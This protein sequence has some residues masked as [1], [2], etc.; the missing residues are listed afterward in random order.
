MNLITSDTITSRDLP[1]LKEAM[2]GYAGD[3]TFGDEFRA[4]CRNVVAAIDQARDEDEA[5][6]APLEASLSAWVVAG[7]AELQRCSRIRDLFDMIGD[8]VDAG[9]VRTVLLDLLPLLPERHVMAMFEAAASGL[10]D[11]AE[12]VIDFGLA[13]LPAASDQLH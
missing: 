11:D 1:A 9:T 10:L 4:V 8:A 6:H 7:E 3:A 12:P 5:T 13:D 2:Y